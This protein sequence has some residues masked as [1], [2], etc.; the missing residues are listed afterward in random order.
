M[1]P[2]TLGRGPSQRTIA[3]D[4]FCNYLQ[5]AARILVHKIFRILLRQPDV[6]VDIDIGYPQVFGLFA[7]QLAKHGRGTKFWQMNYGFFSCRGQ[8]QAARDSW[9]QKYRA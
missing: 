3:F 7:E 4:L 1:D 2:P 9:E 5:F 6:L 8:C